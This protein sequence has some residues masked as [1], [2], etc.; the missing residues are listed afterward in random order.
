MLTFFSILVMLCIVVS[1]FFMPALRAWSI[2]YRKRIRPLVVLGGC[3]LLILLSGC[4]DSTASSV[5]AITPVTMSPGAG[6]P[7]V[8]SNTPAI[9]GKDWTTYH[10]DNLHS[11]YLPQ[12]PDPQQLTG[13]WKVKLDGAVYA[14]P[15]VVHNHVIVATEG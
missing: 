5:P 10:Y 7:T 8:S 6:S 12:E 4:G 1:L 13:A 9:A 14:E 15:L 3:A 11:G 2:R